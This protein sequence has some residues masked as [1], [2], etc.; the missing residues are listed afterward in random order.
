MQTNSDEFGGRIFLP[1]DWQHLA[2]NQLRGKDVVLHA[3]T[4]AGKTFVFEQFIESGFKGRSV[5]TVPTGH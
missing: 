5:Y 4:G 1:D 3:P 2:L